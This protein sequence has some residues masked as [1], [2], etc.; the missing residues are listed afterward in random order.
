MPA[1]AGDP[2]LATG[3]AST[4]SGT[5]TGASGNSTSFPLTARVPIRCDVWGTFGSGTFQPQYSPDNGTTWINYSTTTLTANGG[6]PML[7][8]VQGDLLRV[9]FTGATAAS[10]S[11]R[12]IEMVRK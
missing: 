3:A 8:I 9:T 4:A 6:V 5:L 7:D 1:L 2:N 12:F 11:Y 10:V